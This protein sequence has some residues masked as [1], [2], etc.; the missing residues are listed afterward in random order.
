MPS[1]HRV[2]EPSNG[3]TRV[4]FTLQ[5]SIRSQLEGEARRQHVSMDELLLHAA[6]VYLADLDAAPA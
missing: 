3:S 2:L 4:A 6:L 5:S 1:F